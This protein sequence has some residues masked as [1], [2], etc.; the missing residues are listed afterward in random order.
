ML[1][2]RNIQLLMRY[3]I[4]PCYL[5]IM[6]HLLFFAQFRAHTEGGY[7]LIPFRSILG[8]FR[9]LLAPPLNLSQF[10]F[11]FTNFIGNIVAFYPIPIVIWF[12]FKPKLNHRYGLFMVLL[13]PFLIESVQLVFHRGHFNIDDM[14]LNGF[15]ILIGLW[16]LKTVLFKEKIPG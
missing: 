14:L 11:W 9:E 4:G 7:N 2:N 16:Q 3:A 12:M 5:A 8:Y 15:G 10:W 6:L 1:T 13:I